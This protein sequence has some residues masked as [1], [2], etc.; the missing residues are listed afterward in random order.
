LL[1]IGVLR[2]VPLGIKQKTGSAPFGGTERDIVRELA[3][4][5]TEIWIPALVVSWI[6]EGVRKKPEFFALSQVVE[7]RVLSRKQ[8]PCVSRLVE[9][10]IEEWMWAGVCHFY[11]LCEEVEEPSS[12]GYRKVRKLG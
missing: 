11:V 3:R 9:L 5:T 1:R 4:E 7:Q 12:P 8:S 2:A 6:E 10:R